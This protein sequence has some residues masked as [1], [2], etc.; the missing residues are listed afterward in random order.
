VF[1]NVIFEITTIDTEA[2]ID[3]LTIIRSRMHINFCSPT[4]RNC[5]F[6]DNN[7]FGMDGPGVA[8]EDGM[9][10]FSVNGG[11]MAIYNGSPLIQN[12]L[13][14]D[15]SV[16]GG[17]GGPGANAPQPGRD[18]GWAGWAY[19]G[20]VYIG[21]GS[22][23]KFTDCTFR[24]CFALGGNG[25]DGGNDTGAPPIHGGRGGNYTWSP[26]EETG[27]FTFPNWYWWDGWAWGPYDAEGYPVYG[28]YYRDYWKYSGYGGAVYIEN[29]SDPEFVDCN[30]VNNHSY[31]GVS[32][33]GGDPFPTPDVRMRIENFGGAVYACY[34]SEPSFT[35]CNFSNNTAD[36]TLDANEY[37]IFNQP[38]DVYVSYGGTIAVEDGAWMT[39]VDCNI[40]GGDASIGGGIYWS[41]AG[42]TISDCNIS[43]STAYHG[44]GLYATDADGTI[45]GTTVTRNNA[46]MEPLVI[47]TDAN[48]VPDPNALF[49]YDPGLMFGKGGGYYSLSSMVDV[50]D[51]VFVDNDASSS[52]G[53]IFYS[54]SDQVLNDTPLL[55]NSLVIENRAGRDGGGV[56]VNW[57]AGLTISNSTIADNVVTGSISESPGLGGGLYCSYQSI[58]DVMN[59]IIWDNFAIEGSQVAIAAGSVY[60]PRQSEVNITYTDVGPPFDPNELRL[61]AP[62]RFEGT[63]PVP[64]GSGI[65]RLVDG[66]DI[67]AKFDAGQTTVNVIV[68]LVDPSEIRAT[69]DWDSAESVSVL[70]AEIARRQS[71]V[72]SA[73]TPTEFAPRHAYENLSA[74][75]GAVTRNGL[76]KL[77]ANPVVAH[78]EPVRAVQPML[79]QA[80][81]LVAYM[82]APEFQLRLLIRVSIIRISSLAA[83]ASRTARLSAVMTLV[84]A[85]AIHSPIRCQASWVWKHTGRRA[86]VFR[87]ALCW[88]AFS[89]SMIAS[90]DWCVTHRNDDPI[91]PIKVISNSIG[92]PGLPFNDPHVAD[93]FSPAATHAADTAVGLGITILASSGNDG[94]PG[95]GISWPSAISKVISVG[96]VFDTTDQVTGY[97]NTHEMLDILGPADPVY[98]L[99]ISGLGGFTPGDY[100][101]A[102]NGTSSSCPFVAGCVADIQ[103]SAR[104]KL[105]RYLTPYEV[106]DILASTGDPVTDTKVDLTKPRVNLGR[107]L[108]GSSGPPIYI[109]KDCVLNDFVAPDSNSYWAWDPN[110]DPDSGNIQE[111]PFFTAGYYLGQI[112]AGQIAESNC[113][114]GGI[115]S[116]GDVGLDAYTTRIDGANDVNVVDMGYHYDGGVDI[117]ELSVTVVEDINDPGVH[118]TIDPNGGRFYD[119]TVVT[120]RAY[121]DEG[122][123]L[124]GWYDGNDVRVS[125]AREFDVVMDSDKVFY[126][127][128]RE[129]TEIEV[130][131]GEEALYDAVTVAENGDTLIMAPGTYNGDIDFRG[132]EIAIVSSNPDD[133]NI[134]AGTII[135][136]RNATRGFTFDSGEGPGALI[137]GLTIINGGLFAQP[138]GGIYIGEGSSPTIVNVAISDCNVSFAGGAGIYVDANSSPTFRSV[139]ISNCFTT[140]GSGAGVFVDF[141]STPTFEFCTIE[142]CTA[143]GYGGGLYSNTLSDISYADC[144]FTH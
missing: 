56:S 105:G 13:F 137:D 91:N 15:C 36:K 75:S 69:T 57:L 95:W 83:E 31:G 84:R 120:L 49:Q 22:S 26:S 92:I 73:L 43:D 17:D 28:G 65:A 1:E 38:E 46:R 77:L 11:A 90:W 82:T 133:P 119:G 32:G 61:D 100:W 71:V 99:D 134:V 20:A 102:F 85:T 59:S 97:S 14:T 113:V 55:H 27:P 78:V 52:G 74:L 141:N 64:D 93:A 128:F 123:F 25:G 37:D 6:R 63:G 125:Y 104:A 140:N 41:N 8:G 47:P 58:V 136:C 44:A 135:D 89:D 70:H 16:T 98:T 94:F 96:A 86:R 127:R 33:L 68:T 124:K 80:M 23:P 7:W 132:K 87:P 35:S 66:D 88:Q 9:D 126:A 39:L 108:T 107:A 48:G 122:Y 2:I 29:D 60:E 101:P 121:P 106:R 51:S 3:G 139:T 21:Y 5:V 62:G 18:G 115:G 144:N 76:G 4:V 67:Y 72:T 34:G 79:R 50:A 114:D 130:S 112:A 117:F 110:W 30:F 81:R 53:G 24:N 116:P 131:G 19:G 129:P 10:G 142:G 138:G 12:C 111:D 103:Q 109:E 143:D 40:A 118:G 54:G 42:M 45:T